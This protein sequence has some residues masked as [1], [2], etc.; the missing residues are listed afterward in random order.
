MEGQFGLKS[1][2]SAAQVAQACQITTYGPNVEAMWP[3]LFRTAALYNLH[4][5]REVMAGL[6]GVIAHET[7]HRW[8]PIHEFGN[9]AD[10]NRYGRAPNGQ[11]YGG[12]GLI[13]TTWPGNYAVLQDYV[14]RFGI[15]VDLINNPDALLDDLVLAAH[16]AL[17]YFV[18]HANGACI[19]M[20][21]QHDWGHVVYYVWGQYSPGVQVFDQYYNE[22]KYAAEY[23]LAR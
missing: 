5:D 3:I 6:C 15:D 1:Y 4:N 23:L 8:W 13:Q 7:A 14:K 17:T 12:R 10:F 21:H 16:G 20:C 18:T 22:V 9:A 2:W 11:D 19:N